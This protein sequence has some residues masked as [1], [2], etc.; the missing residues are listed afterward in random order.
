MDYGYYDTYTTTTTAG[1]G[2]ST[3]L[4]GMILLIYFISVIG[5]IVSIIAMWKI[6]TKA[7]KPGWASII[8]IYNIVILFEIVELE[9]W[10]V[11]IAIFVPFAFL[12]YLIVIDIKLAKVFGQGIGVILLFIFI[13]VIGQLILAFGKATYKPEIDYLVNQGN[14]NNMVNNVPMDNKDYSTMNVN[15]NDHYYNAELDHMSQKQIEEMVKNNMA[16]EQN[17]N[18]VN[19]DGN[20]FNQVNNNDLNQN[21]MNN[22]VNINNDL[23][24]INNMNQD[25]I[26][27]LDINQPSTKVCPVCGSNQALDA[28][29]CIICGNKFM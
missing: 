21:T 9:W 24:N 4:G 18:Q 28:S 16:Q 27:Q 29:V 13:P 10:H 17:T 6:Y 15:S 2:L 7:G 20:V 22:Q 5:S 26:E 25:N 12:I 23:N 8:P 14:M 1:S 19:N 11:L 3:A